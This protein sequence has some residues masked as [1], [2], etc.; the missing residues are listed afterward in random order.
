MHATLFLAGAKKKM[1]KAGRRGG[2]GAAARASADDSECDGD[3]DGVTHSD[4]CDLEDEEDEI[5]DEPEIIL[6]HDHRNKV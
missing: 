6:C 5:T 4:E 3:Q 1:K 2:G